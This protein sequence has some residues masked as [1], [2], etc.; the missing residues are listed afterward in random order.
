MEVEGNFKSDK[1]GGCYSADDA[2][3]CLDDAL[4]LLVGQ[5]V[6]NPFFVDSERNGCSCNGIRAHSLIILF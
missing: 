6:V 4:D 3:F 1:S 2:L 5:D